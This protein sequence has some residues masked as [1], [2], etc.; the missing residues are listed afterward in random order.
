M[1]LFLVDLKTL[2]EEKHKEFTGVSNKQILDNLRRLSG[3]QK[4]VIVRIPVIP[5]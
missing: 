4:K 3:Q 2:D 1:D 5:G